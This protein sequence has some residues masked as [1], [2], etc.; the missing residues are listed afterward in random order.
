MSLKE[1][2]DSE[3]LQIWKVHNVYRICLS[4]FDAVSFF[5]LIVPRASGNMTINGEQVPNT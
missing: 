4:K 1:A 5:V 3:I 2:K